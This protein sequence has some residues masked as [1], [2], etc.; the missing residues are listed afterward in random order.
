MNEKDALKHFLLKVY[1]P[2]M[3]KHPVNSVQFKIHY[4]D[5]KMIKM[6]FMPKRLYRRYWLSAIEEERGAFA[7]AIIPYKEKDAV[8][9]FVELISKSD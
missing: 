3:L 4:K 8:K 9:Y 5:R 1:L 6:F 7:K 2:D